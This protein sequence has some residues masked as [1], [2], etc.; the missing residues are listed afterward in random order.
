LDGDRIVE[1]RDLMHGAED[2][3][4]RA[5]QSN[6]G[7]DWSASL[8]NGHTTSTTQTSATSVGSPASAHWSASIGTGQV[9]DESTQRRQIASKVLE[10]Q[11]PRAHWTSKIGTARAADSSTSTKTGKSP[12]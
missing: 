6:G 5:E 11:A 1:Q 4:W 3:A 12:S 10:S 7:R 8:G 2:S 9:R